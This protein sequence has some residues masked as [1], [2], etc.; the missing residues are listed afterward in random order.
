MQ[1]D[2]DSRQLAQL[3]T[4][5]GL[6]L[7]PLSMNPDLHPVHTVAEVQFA[8][9]ARTQ[10]LQLVTLFEPEVTKKYPELQTEH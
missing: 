9:F 4:A 1:V 10:G 3:R 7:P 5:Q 6:Q 8:Q 2:I